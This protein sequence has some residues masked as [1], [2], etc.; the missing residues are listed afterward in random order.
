ME[1]EVDLVCVLST[2][3]KAHKV[4]GKSIFSIKTHLVLINKLFKANK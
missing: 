3:D 2:D 1:K 4:N